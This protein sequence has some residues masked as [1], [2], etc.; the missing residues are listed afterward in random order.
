M[1]GNSRLGKQNVRNMMLSLSVTVLLAGFVWLFL[2]HDG[3][4]DPVL[5]PVDYRVELITARRA[6]PYP[7]VAPQGLSEEWKPTSVRYRG[8]ESA[9]WH[10]GFR[11]P[12]EKYVAVE[13][14]T[15]KPSAFVD[16][17]TRGARDTGAA[18]D[19]DG[20]A[21]QKFEG[22]RYDALVRTEDGA[23]TVVMGSA[24]FTR[25]TMM[26]QALGTG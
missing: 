18:Q 4:R 13:Q 1:A 11:T 10:L 3:D 9:H 16:R 25:L 19:V 14:S 26:A 24:S 20:R 8:A 21:W 2:P 5:K 22:E 12:D 23:T 7:V 15:E 6:A 17:V